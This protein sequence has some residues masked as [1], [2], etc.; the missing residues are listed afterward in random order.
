MGIPA[1]ALLPF[2]FGSS[3]GGGGGG[4]STYI[5]SF[6]S[7]ATISTGTSWSGDDPYTSTV[8][9][10]GYTVTNKTMVNV[11]PSSDVVEQMI[12]DGTTNIFITN[13]SGTLTATA[14]GA[15]PTAAMTLQVLCTESDVSEDIAGLPAIVGDGIFDTLEANNL[16][17]AVNQLSNAISQKED[18]LSIVQK[19]SSDVTITLEEDKFY[20]FPTM[21]E[22]TVTCP[23][24]GLYGFRFTS[25]TTPTVFLMSGITMPDNWN[26]TEASKTYDMTI[27]NGL[28]LVTSW[29]V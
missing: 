21:T 8:T 14:I 28:A 6:G 25:G 19:T 10:T 4:D 11:L 16:T 26:G 1:E 17:D 23:L 2:I 5:P 15:A 24:T 20:I 18:A 12:E 7:L 29:S 27:L 22:L 9:V 13:N 3:G